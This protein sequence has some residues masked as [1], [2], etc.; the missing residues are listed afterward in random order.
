MR[1]LAMQQHIGPGSR[2]DRSTPPARGQGAGVSWADATR[3]ELVLLRHAINK[4]WPIA[5]HRRRPILDDIVRHLESAEPRTAIGVARVV[6][7]A[8]QSNLRGLRA[9]LTHHRPMTPHASGGDTETRATENGPS[10]P[11]HTQSLQPD[12]NGQ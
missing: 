6:L 5:Q 8:D 4:D 7:A 3:S 10:A 11:N 1:A 2:G 12:D 9:G